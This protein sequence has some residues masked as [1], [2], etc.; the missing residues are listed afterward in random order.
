MQNILSNEELLIVLRR[1]L[2]LDSEQKAAA[3]GW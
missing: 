2:N 1:Q 3:I